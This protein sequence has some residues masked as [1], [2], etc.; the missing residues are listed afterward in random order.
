[1]LRPLQN[2]SDVCLA[3]IIVA[4]YAGKGKE[5]EHYGHEIAA[6]ASNLCGERILGKLDAVVF[7][8]RDTAEKD[9]EGSAGTDYERIGKDS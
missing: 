2:V 1:M 3:V 5:E 6:H 9:Y 7:I 8:K 4:Y